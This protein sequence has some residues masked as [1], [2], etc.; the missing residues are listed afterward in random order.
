MIAFMP[1]LPGM[2][3]YAWPE[4]NS[5]E[6]EEDKKTLYSYPFIFIVKNWQYPPTLTKLCLMSTLELK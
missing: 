3:F 2:H 6:D 4:L 1:K 5:T